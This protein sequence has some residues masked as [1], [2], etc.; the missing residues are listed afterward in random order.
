MVNVTYDEGGLIVATC[1][2]V[3]V[4]LIAGPLR[5]AFLE[6][7][8]RVGRELGNEYPG[9]IGSLTLT[10]PNVELPDGAARSLTARMTKESNDWVKAGAT[11]VTGRGFKASAARSVLTAITLVGS[12]K[13]PRKVFDDGPAAVDWLTAEVGGQRA[14]AALR[15]W[16]AKRGFG[17]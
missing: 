6:E 14:R 15:L 2:R 10:T 7:A 4:T 11:V 8:H 12:R 5:T 17:E 13:P 16:C 3:L 9:G 1:E